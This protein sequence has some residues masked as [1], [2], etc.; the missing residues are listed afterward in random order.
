MAF[1]AFCASATVGRRGC[2]LR[3]D[4]FYP[5]GGVHFQDYNYNLETGALV[6]CTHAQRPGPDFI[7]NGGIAETNKI[8]ICSEFPEL[9][10]S[11][12][13]RFQKNSQNCE[14]F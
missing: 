4:R 11:D 3:A 13:S 9:E 5:G 1:G 6:G 10:K 12:K 8:P 7:R 2:T 14:N